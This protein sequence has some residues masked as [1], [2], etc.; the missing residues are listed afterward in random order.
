MPEG[1][2]AGFL[3]IAAVFGLVWLL[4][5]TTAVAITCVVRHTLYASILAVGAVV[6]FVIAIFW[7]ATT[8]GEPPSS[9]YLLGMFGGACLLTTVLGWWLAKRDVVVYQ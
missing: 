6:L 1:Q 2:Q 9:A 3:A 4:I 8:I 7:R 5:F